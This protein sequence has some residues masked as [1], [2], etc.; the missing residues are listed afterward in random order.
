MCIKIGQEQP[1][2]PP[3]DAKELFALGEKKGVNDEED[4]HILEDCVR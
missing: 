3:R 2:R 1:I 4:P